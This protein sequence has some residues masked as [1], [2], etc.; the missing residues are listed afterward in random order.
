LAVH[1]FEIFK[2]CS[3]TCH[4]QRQVINAE[5]SQIVCLEMFAKSLVS[6]VLIEAPI[7]MRA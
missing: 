3:G 1:L 4:G 2:E 7:F 6:D 5:T